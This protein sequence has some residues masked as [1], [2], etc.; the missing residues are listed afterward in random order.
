M[1]KYRVKL[2]DVQL[3]LHLKRGR[4]I[5]RTTCF[6]TFTESPRF[7]TKPS[8]SMTVK[9]KQ[10]VTLPC[11][12]AGFPSPLITWYKDGNIIAGEK[13]HFNKRNLEILNILYEDHGIYT[14][15]AENLLG[16]V[17]L[18]INV[19]VYGKYNKDNNGN[20]NN[21]KQKFFILDTCLKSIQGV[22]VAGSSFQYFP[23]LSV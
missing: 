3:D 22:Q 21:K 5:T 19:T 10:N 8:P 17:Q 15:T 2:A 14:C 6:N 20:I 13:K 18:S 7:V 23:R 1:F 12:A 16:R 9:E 11:K 4:G